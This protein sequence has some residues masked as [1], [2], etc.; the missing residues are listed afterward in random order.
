MKK[1]TTRRS[2]PKEKCCYD[3]DHCI[4]IGDGDHLCDVDNEIVVNDWEPT[5]EFYHCVG[6]DFT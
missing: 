3:G 2:A 5:E 4:Y 1:R 6:K